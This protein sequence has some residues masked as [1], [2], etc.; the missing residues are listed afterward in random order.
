M[1]S[2]QHLPIRP[3][4]D[5][6]ARLLQQALDDEQSTS[7]AVEIHG[8]C[9]CP[10]VQG[11]IIP[12]ARLDLIK[13]GGKVI[14]SEPPPMFDVR[15]TGRRADT[16]T[17]RPV[18]PRIATTDWFACGPDDRETFRE[19][20]QNEINWRRQQT[21][22]MKKLA[23]LA[24][25]A[26]L[27]TYVRQDRS[28]RVWERLADIIDQTKPDLMPQDAWNM[29]AWERTRANRTKQVKDFLEEMLKN[30]DYDHMTHIIIQTGTKPLVAA[31]TFLIL[32]DNSGYSS[33]DP[34]G[35]ARR[36]P[37]FITA[38]PASWGQTVIRSWITPYHP[39]LTYLDMDPS[40][41][42]DRH[43]HAQA[44]S[45]LLL[46]QTEVIALSPSVWKGYGTAKR[47]TIRE[48]FEKTVP[49]SPSPIQAVE[50]AP[51][52]QLLNLF[53]TTPFVT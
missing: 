2:F 52:P 18:S 8:P 47:Q 10:T 51:D 9:N 42:P 26:T 34:T 49:Y 13:V 40:K 53:N 29:A 37:Q 4:Q 23:L 38:Y 27:P 48:H 36:V 16:I 3:G 7:C 30:R 14:V 50:E 19:I 41:A 6:R 15:Q 39:E 17:F 35:P 33:D 24:Y 11:H 21:D 5:E 31:N 22:V 46:Q 12:E 20:E 43:A 25:K 32:S 1:R 45:I 44:S 28:A